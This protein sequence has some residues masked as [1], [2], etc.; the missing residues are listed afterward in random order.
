MKALKSVMICLFAVLLLHVAGAAGAMNA[1][2]FL[3]ESQDR[4]P[5]LAAPGD[6]TVAVS[7]GNGTRMLATRTAN[8]LR[9]LG[10]PITA[11][12]NAET[13]SYAASYILVL[14]GVLGAW[15]LHNALP[16]DARIV[17]P[18]VFEAHHE[19]MRP[20]IPEGTHVVLIVGAGWV[21]E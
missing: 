8:Y 10:F 1:V 15:D 13:F 6:I 14:S 17:F 11:I 3:T 9:V 18:H 4:L 7:N 5:I 19:A 20:F 12:G 21:I 16:D 2:V